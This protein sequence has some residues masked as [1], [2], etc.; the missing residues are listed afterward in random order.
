[1][2]LFRTSNAEI[3]AECQRYFGFSLPNALTEKGNEF[4]NSYNNGSS[5]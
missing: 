1:M 5:F 2:N 3:I 4:V